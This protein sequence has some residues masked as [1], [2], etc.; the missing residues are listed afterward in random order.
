[1]RLE[2]GDEGWDGFRLAEIAGKGGGLGP[3]R[4]Q[5][6]HRGVELVLLACRQ[7][8]GRTIFAQGLGHLKS[9]AA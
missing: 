6:G 2:P 1:M 5:L 7:D 9:E 8:H 3:L 4:R